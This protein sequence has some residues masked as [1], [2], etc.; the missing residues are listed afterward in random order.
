M[1]GFLKAN[2][3]KKLTKQIAKMQAQAVQLQRSGDLRKYA[4]MMTEVARLEDE[5]E[6]ILS[7]KSS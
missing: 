1:L 2:P 6:R 3:E 4:A 7:P 5:L